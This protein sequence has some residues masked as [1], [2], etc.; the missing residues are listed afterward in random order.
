MSS[1]MQSFGSAENIHLSKNSFEDEK[2][3]WLG[4]EYLTGKSV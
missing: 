2:M 3:E 4:K 1:G